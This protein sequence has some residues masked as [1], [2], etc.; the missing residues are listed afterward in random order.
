MK[1]NAIICHSCGDTIFSRARHDCRPCSCGKVFI[2]GGF[3]YLR[4]GGE[5]L[6]KIIHKTINILQ[7]KKELYDDWNLKKDKYGIIKNKMKKIII[8]C[9]TTVDDFF[10]NKIINGGILDPKIE[11]FYLSLLNDE[12]TKI[13]VYFKSVK[14]E[15]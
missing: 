10:A 11:L 1:V 6:D 5:N 7:T 3:D 2:D 4:V 13:P 14:I 12:N 15:K 8:E 9:Q